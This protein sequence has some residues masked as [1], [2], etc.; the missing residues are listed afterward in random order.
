MGVESKLSTFIFDGLEE[1]KYLREIYQGILKHY[2]AKLFNTP[3]KERYDISDALRFADLLSHSVDNNKS[4]FHKNIA[5]SIV[6]ILSFLYPDNKK[7]LLYRE[8]V[9]KNVNNYAGLDNFFHSESEQNINGDYLLHYFLDEY[10]KD[11]LRV[12][13]SKNLKFIGSQKEIFEKLDSDYLSF[14]APTSM[15]KSFL[16][17]MFMKNKISKGENKD[18]A[19]IVPTKALISETYI[20]VINDLQTELSNHNYRVIRSVNEIQNEDSHKHIFVMTPE[21]LLYLLMSNVKRKLGY[22]FIDESQRISANDT[23]STFYYQVI[24]LLQKE[25]SKP[26]ISFASPNIPNPQIYLNLIGKEKNKS[27]RRIS[28]SPV[29]QIYFTIDYYEMKVK[30]FNNLESDFF[31]ICSIKS[32]DILNALMF[33]NKAASENQSLVYCNKT[34]DAINYALKMSDRVSFKTNDPVLD[35]LASKISNEIHADYYLAEL[36]RKGIA[37]HVGYLPEE[38]RNDI[39]DAYRSKH[40][41]TIFCTSTLMEG[42]N[43]PAS[44]LFVTSTRNGKKNYNEIDFYNLNGRI[45]RLGYA[46]MG[47]VFLIIKDEKDFYRFKSFLT[48]SVPKQKLSVEEIVTRSNVKKIKKA[49]LKGDITLKNLYD[50]LSYS[51]SNTL[52]KYTLIF[53]RSLQ[54]NTKGVV[55]TTFEK[56]LTRDEEYKILSKLEEIYPKQRIDKDINIS[57]DQNVTIKKLVSAGES[58]PKINGNSPKYSETLAFLEKLAIAYNWEQYEHSDLGKKSNG[59]FKQLRWYAVILIQWISG[60]GLSNILKESIE[61]RKNSPYKA[62]WVNGNYEDY[63]GTRRQNN[64]IINDTLKALQRQIIFKLSN[65]FLKYAKEY[66]SYYQL[67]TL[68]NNWYE[69]IE[70]GTSNELRIWLQKNGYSREAASFIEKHSE[71]YFYTDE[72]Y[73]LSSKLKEL[74]DDIGIQTVRISFNRPEI[75]ID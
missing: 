75:F 74:N 53:L 14:S 33:L 64:I 28:F 15:G 16:M 3:Y 34:S 11:S 40:I 31:E 1:N 19:L 44:N 41:D 35:K 43:L 68:K 62:L 56:Y 8:R 58:F 24:D 10:Q 48:K 5:Q 17:R 59:E 52:R 27:S 46:M 65:Y 36:V 47:N 67:D 66:R 45:G 57:L 70:Y 50:S 60:Y 38:I 54:N 26:L 32:K 21:R 63:I 71:Y 51:S 39:E 73:R 42:V 25:A 18:F 13:G 12:P 30:C 20:K 29:N 55:R 7:V 22:V 61:Y 72:G 6:S 49:L 2:G 23:R 37:F 9:L 69:F 4:D